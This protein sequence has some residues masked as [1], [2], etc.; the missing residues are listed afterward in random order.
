MM[1]FKS[2]LKRNINKYPKSE[3]QDLLKLIYQSQYGTGHIVNN[4]N[5][6]FNFLNEEL[7]EV[8]TISNNLLYEYISNDYIRLNLDTFI[9]TS[10]PLEELNDMFIQTS[11]IKNESNIASKICILEDFYNNEEIT[12]FKNNP[13]QKHHSETY[14]KYYNPHYRLIHKS[15]LDVKYKS[16]LINDYISNLLK[17]LNKDDLYL[18]ALEGKCA[19]GKTTLS[20]NIQNVTIIHVDDFFSNTNDPLQFDKIRDIINNLKPNK[21]FTYDVY[22]CMDNSFS[23][24]HIDSV[25][26]IVIF[27][28][29][30]SYHEKI[31]DLFNEVIYVN[32]AHNQLER[33]LKRCNGNTILYNKFINIWIPRENSYYDSFDFILNASLII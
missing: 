8:P 14:R 27:E 1:Y 10:F 15:L 31:R 20:K 9:K 19:S 4:P 21:P 32:E 2:Y 25:S 7:K 23:S 22:N 16:Y 12:D 18:I 28:G 6:S 26:N 17:N 11:F 30:Y 24:K 5:F 33:L 3:T 13:V 29:V